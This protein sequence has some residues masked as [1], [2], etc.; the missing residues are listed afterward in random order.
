MV[1]MGELGK[2]RTWL[3]RKGRK[4]DTIG[5]YIRTLS[6]FDGEVGL[7]RFGTQSVLDWFLGHKWAPNSSRRH[8]YA[9]RAYSLF[10]GIKLDWD[11]IPVPDPAEEGF[12][13][14]SSREVQRLFDACETPRERALFRIGYD[15]L[16]RVGELARLGHSHVNLKTGEVDLRRLK[17]GS[18]IRTKLD[19]DT[20]EVLKEYVEEEKPKGGR[21]FP[22][23]R[24]T[25]I[26]MFRGVGKRARIPKVT[27]HVL[28][29]SRATHLLNEAGWSLLD[30]KELGGWRDIRNVQRYLKPSESKITQKKEKVEGPRMRTKVG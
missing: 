4:P 23:D 29:H 21:L 13:A 25:I 16:M 28:R 1:K 11:R 18:H 7:G 19:P 22:F 10:S 6:Q 24:Q 12:R 26:L 15:L 3:E 30:V 9:L 2:F 27:P 14:L 20:L 8:A 17:K 5:S